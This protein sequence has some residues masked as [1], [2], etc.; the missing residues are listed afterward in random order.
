MKFSLFSDL[1]STNEG[2]SCS[3][4]SDAI[5]T[6]PGLTDILIDLGRGLY[7]LMFQLLLLIEAD[8]KIAVYVYHTLQQN[9]KVIENLLGKSV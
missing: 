6:D 3:N 7:K 1:D 9:E 8:H 5:S 2:A 4:I